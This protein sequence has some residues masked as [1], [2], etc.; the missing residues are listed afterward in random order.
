MHAIS[1]VLR[2]LS[3]FMYGDVVNVKGKGAAQGKDTEVDIKALRIGMLRVQGILD[4]IFASQRFNAALYQS[5]YYS[6][7]DL[8]NLLIE[9]SRAAP[10]HVTYL[11]KFLSC[12]F[13]G[14]FT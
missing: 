11:Q 3:R 14:R 1:S 5:R 10:L 4:Y 6:E 7:I 8:A 13:L 12:D 9:S 2:S